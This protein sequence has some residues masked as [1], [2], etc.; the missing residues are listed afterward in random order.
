MQNTNKIQQGQSFVDM[1]CQLTGSYEEVLDMAI[2]NNKSITTPLVIGNEVKG[3]A[4]RNQS[5]VNQFAKKQ[6]ATALEQNTDDAIE[7]LEGIGYWIINKTFK[8]S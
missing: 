5:I 2:L 3:S 8:V 4:V 6:P 7:D 1:V